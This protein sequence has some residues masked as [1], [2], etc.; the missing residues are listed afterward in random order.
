MKKVILTFDE[1]DNPTI[2]V[3]GCTGPE[4]AMLTKAVEEALGSVRTDRKLPEF[5]VMSKTR[6]RTKTHG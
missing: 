3:N 6:E 5:H 1:N 4:C 2:E